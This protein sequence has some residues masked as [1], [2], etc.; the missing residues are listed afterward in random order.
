MK[1]HLKFLDVEASMD[2]IRKEVAVDIIA[3]IPNYTNS[4]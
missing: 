3:S 4:K 2:L 1:L